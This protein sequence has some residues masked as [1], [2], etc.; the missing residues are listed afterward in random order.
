[1]RKPKN[2]FVTK[3]GKDIYV[4]MME[5][6]PAVEHNL[7]CWLCRE[8]HAVYSMHPNWVFKPCWECQSKLGLMGVEVKKWYQF[9]K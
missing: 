5:Y 9:W 1:M 4:E 2:T 6:G 8:N 3:L 7:M